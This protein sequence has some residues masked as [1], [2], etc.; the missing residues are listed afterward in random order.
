ME[1]MDRINARALQNRDGF[2]PVSTSPLDEFL[3]NEARMD[4]EQAHDGTLLPAER[5]AER[6]GTLERFLEFIFKEGPHPGLVTG[7]LYG[8]THAIRADLLGKCSMREIGLLLGVTKADISWRVK[9]VYN[10]TI[11]RAGGH[12]TRCGVQKGT[13]RNYRGRRVIDDPV[14]RE[15]ARRV[16]EGEARLKEGDVPPQTRR[17]LRIKLA[18]LKEEMRCRARGEK[19]TVTRT[20]KTDT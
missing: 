6:R 14:Y 18:D 19:F 15:L 17:H 7:R 2:A 8:V 3:A 16:A 11:E 10:R 12:E 9:K 20:F 13:T 5:A 4:E 1:R